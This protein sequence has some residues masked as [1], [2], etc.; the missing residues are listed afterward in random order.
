MKKR[1]L[2]I[3]LATC[4]LLTLLPTTALA[5][6]VPVPMTIEINGTYHPESNTISDGTEATGL[7]LTTLEEA[8][9]NSGVA[10]SGI[11]ILKITAGTVT[12][13]DWMYI[14]SLTAL[15]HFEIA[16]GV[17]VADMPDGTTSNITFPA[18]ILSVN[19]PQAISI[20]A[21]AYA[22][23]SAMGG[24]AKLTTVSLPKVTSIG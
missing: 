18:T 23:P 5:G 17:T 16:D 2:S 19:I 11:Q 9:G 21:Y 24:S 20:G 12:E 6:I 1:L 22:F 7:S 3:A 8:I 14:K 13:A 4:M 15:E 10:A